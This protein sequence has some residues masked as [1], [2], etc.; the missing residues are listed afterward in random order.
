MPQLHTLQIEPIIK[1]A[2]EE[3]WGAG[4]W[5]TD[6]CVPPNRQAS[7]QIVAKAPATI[8]GM[9]V[10]KAVFEYVDPN[11]EIELK[12][13]NGDSV[14]AGTSLMTMRG[15]SRC[16]L[17]A[18]RVALNFLAHMSGIATET[19]K[20][21][22]QLEP[23]ACDLLDTRKTTPGLRI[24]EKSATAT[25][26]ARNHR[27]CLTDGVLIKENHIRA[28]G[29]IG[30]AVSGLL[31]SLPPTIKIEVE[32][33]TLAEVHEA[34]EAGA[35]LI[36]LDNMPVSEMA[37]AVRTVRK[38]ALLEASGN[39]TLS[40]IVEIAETGVDFVSTSSILYGATWADLS[41]LFDT[42]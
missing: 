6:L 40:N 33:G 39:V 13:H 1:R 23:F 16:L 26:G 42:V 22:R 41:L 19:R 10:A 36:M 12:Q 30:P 37:M 35:H 9:E 5:T 15:D 29:G 2:L 31:E 17:K 38:R 25:G 3:D 14:P 32:T 11:C 7:A 28:A 4:D 21:V 27:L 34:L 18:E 20:Y 24:L 8:C